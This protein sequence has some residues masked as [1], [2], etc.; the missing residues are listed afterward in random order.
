MTSQLHAE[1]YLATSLRLFRTRHTEKSSNAAGSRHDFS[2]HGLLSRG[3]IYSWRPTLILSEGGAPVTQLASF[4][5]HFLKIFPPQHG[6]SRNQ[7]SSR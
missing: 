7:A 6:H 4:R 1:I 2:S 3:L 5:L